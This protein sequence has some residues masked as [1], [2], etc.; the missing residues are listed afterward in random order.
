MKT[1]ADL[2]L[3]KLVMKAINE[4][5]YE[6]PTPIQLKAIPQL[7]D[8]K[9]LLGIAQT[10]TGK[11]AAFALPTLDYLLEEPALRVPKS[12]R[13]LVLAPTRELAS[14]IAESFSNYSRYM[15]CVVQTVF[16]GVK[17]NKQIRDLSKGT[18]VLVATPGRLLDLAS[19]G[20]VTLAD[21][22]V[23]ILDEADQML[24]MGFI[25][26][27][28]KIIA[29][30]PKDRQTLLFS[31]TMP[32]SISELANQFLDHPVR[33]SVAPESTTAERVN[34][35]VIH[36]AAGDKPKLL[37]AVLKDPKIN[38]ALV[39]T[40]TKHGAD[41]VVR[42]LKGE[43]IEAAAIHGN[44]SQPQRMKALAA[45]KDGHCKVLVATDIA[46]R[47]ID[48]SGITH[49]V[50]YEMPNVPEQYVHRIGR[51]ARAGKDGLA[52][53]L[54]AADE[55]Y[56]LRDIEKTIRQSIPVLDVP[57]GADISA[58]P[59]PDPSIRPVKPKGPSGGRGGG[60]RRRGG[61]HGGGQKRRSGGGGNRNRNRS[62]SKAPA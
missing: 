57:E 29:Q 39:F 14:Q 17:I 54:I 3:H 18:H 9:D 20:A 37:G 13:V 53:S 50:N 61:G 28:K 40:R 7:L 15:D 27:L 60:N 43:G 11:T 24:D 51:T 33:V 47:G 42:K 26:D 12:T 1:F 34:Q 46:A 52:I 49:V 5:G 32:K 36:I 59:T 8:D 23:L 44:K 58:L 16:G 25:H 41:K 2:G 45:F 6:T 10:G 48:I 62:R 56:Y 4:L 31:A 21:I 55:L 35:G 30:I 22:E 19:Q 38:R